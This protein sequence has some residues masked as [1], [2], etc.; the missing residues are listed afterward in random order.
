MSFKIRKRL[1]FLFQRNIVYQISC[2]GCGNQYIDKT[3]HCLQKRLHECSTQQITNEVVQYFLNG[4]HTLYLADSNYLFVH[5]HSN[6]T[7]T[8]FKILYSCRSYNPNILVILKVLLI[9]FYP[10]ELNSGLKASKEWM[11]FR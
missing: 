6:H 11:L 7:P 8:N 9:K 4:E 2:P 1:N 5:L 10:P 3:D